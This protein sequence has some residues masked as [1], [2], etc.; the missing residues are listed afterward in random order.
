[1]IL[2]TEDGVVV[3]PRVAREL[4]REKT[5]GAES[6]RFS[7]HWPDGGTRWSK[8]KEW[9]LLGGDVEK[10]KVSLVVCNHSTT[11]AAQLNRREFLL[12]TR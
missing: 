3:P 12:E 5:P 7:S 4:A 11:P 1:M 9:R 10:E 6:Y 2:P 8:K